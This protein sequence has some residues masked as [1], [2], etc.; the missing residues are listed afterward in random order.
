[1]TRSITILTCLLLAAYI[2]ADAQATTNTFL[3]IHTLRNDKAGVKAAREFMKLAGENRE[4][5]WYQLPGG[6]LAEFEEGTIHNKLVFDRNGNWLYTM[7]EYGEKELPREVRN[8]VKSTYYDFS[9]GWVKEV[10]QFRSTAYVVHINNAPEWKDLIVREGEIE[11][12]RSFE[13]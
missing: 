6:Y 11:V 8:L 10:S 2:P 7:R 12:Q 9:I 13:Q 5:R 1:M 3:N 4:E